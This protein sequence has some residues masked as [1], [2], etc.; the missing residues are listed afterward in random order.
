MALYAGKKFIGGRKPSFIYFGGGT[1]SFIST[2][3]LS[4]IVEAMK[5]QL[6]WDE[7]EEIAFECEPGTITEGKL[8]ILK[9]MGVTRL[10]LGIENF[11]EEI[12]RANGRAHGAEEIGRS[13]EFARSI[14][15]P[16]INVDLIAGMMGESGENW[17]ECVRKTIAL[18]PDS[19]YIASTTSTDA[20]PQSSARWPITAMSSPPW[21][22]S[23]ATATTSAPVCSAIQPIATEVSS[24]PE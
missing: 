8:R 17:R 9:D 1:P 16:Q 21:P 12:L 11:D 7:A 20:A 22:T 23:I 18:A 10:S 6:A 24:P 3:Q 14:G 19:E 4:K 2:R 5:R 15:F 13:Y